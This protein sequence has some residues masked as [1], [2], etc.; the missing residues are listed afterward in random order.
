V[1]VGK[2]RRWII[3]AAIYLTVKMLRKMA[4]EQGTGMG[5]AT[6][7]ID[8]NPH[9]IGLPFSVVGRVGYYTYM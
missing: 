6:L 3:Y 1:L 8:V 7:R 4:V 5:K 2:G 9:Y